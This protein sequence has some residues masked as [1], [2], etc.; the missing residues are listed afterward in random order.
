MRITL[1]ALA[2]TT[3]Q[4]HSE[5]VPAGRVISTDPSSGERVLKGAQIAAVI[6][7]GPERFSMP[8]LAEMDLEQASAAI[9]AANLKVG[10]VTKAYHETAPVGRVLQAGQ[11]PGASLKRDT[12]V[13]LVISQGPR[14]ITV[15][16][17][18]G[19]KLADA[20]AALTKLGF[21]VTHSETN[22]DTAPKGQVISQDPNNGTGRAGDTIKLVVSKGPVMVTVPTVT[23]ADEATAKQRLGNAGLKVKVVYNTE[24]WV[25]LN[26]VAAQDPGANRTAPKGSTVTI[27]VS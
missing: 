9:T 12:P 13:N 5:T 6:S 11:A 10:T 2:F 7:A 21:R 19:Q 24:A 20:T 27:Y 26:V 3:T 23:G 16:N 14:P 18:A 22:S 4:Q 17:L 8:S 1:P 25:R 15:P